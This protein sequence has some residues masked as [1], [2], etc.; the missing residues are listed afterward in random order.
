MKKRETG[1]RQPELLPRRCDLPFQSSQTT[2]WCYGP[3]RLDGVAR[4]RRGHPAEQ[5]E[6]CCWQAATASGADGSAAAEGD[7]AHD[8]ARDGR[9]DSALRAGAGWSVAWP[10]AQKWKSWDE[11]S[12]HA[13]RSDHE[14][15]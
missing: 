8:M 7:A 1:D 10:A 4:V 15:R 9:P 12:T 3:G 5:S 14:S 6:E 13:Q 2:G 11:R